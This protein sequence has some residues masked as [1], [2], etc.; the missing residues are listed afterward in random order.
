M[1]RVTIKD[2]ARQAG[3][4]VT[5]VSQALN[6]PE[7]SRVAAQTRDA[8]RKVADSLGYRAN[9]SARALRTRRT[10]TIALIGQHLA[11]TEFLGGLIGGAQQEVRHHDGLLI[12][13][14]TA[15]DIDGVVQTLRDRQVDGI[16]LGAFYHQ[17]LSVPVS[18]LGTP[19]VLVNAFTRQEGY[20][21][22]TPD[23]VAGGRA[24]AEVLLAAGHRQVAMIGNVDDIPAT[25]GRREGFLARCRQSG[26]EP[27]YVATS[28]HAEATQALS[29]ELLAGPDRP[30]GVFCFS[31]AM[32]IGFYFAAAGL[33]LRI[34][35]D[36]SVVGFDA[37][38]L[39]D[40]SLF[41]HLT[42]VALPHAEMAA[43]AVERLYEQL[44]ARGGAVGTLPSRGER[45]V[46]RVVEGESVSAPPAL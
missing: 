1:T 9:P 33:G 43:W 27:R 22:V 3:V 30:T 16:I 8:V 11:T 34:P 7:G 45:I 31:D 13:A 36:V 37:M 6:N 44:E 10:D 19:T 14:D 23:E 12:V 35:Q 17:E 20:S 2:V 41:P 15:D 4:S 26:I 39:I 29:T 42:S 25:H 21:W 46:G 28:P 32:A 5:T 38:R 40:T 24:A 18:L